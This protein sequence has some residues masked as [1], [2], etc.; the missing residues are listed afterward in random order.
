MENIKPSAP[1]HPLAV[2]HPA[3]VRLVKLEEPLESQQRG[4]RSF[5][6]QL[7]KED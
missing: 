7:T 6:E 3:T 2:L 5:D 4:P 1:H